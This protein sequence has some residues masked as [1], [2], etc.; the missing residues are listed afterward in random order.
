[1]NRKHVVLRVLS[2]LILIS[3]LPGCSVGVHGCAYL[4]INEKAVQEKIDQANEDVKKE[5]EQGLHDE[6]DTDMALAEGEILKVRL[7]YG[8]D[9]AGSEAWYRV[10]IDNDRNG[11]YDYV[12]ITAYTGFGTTLKGY[13]EYTFTAANFN[14][15]WEQEEYYDPLTIDGSYRMTITGSNGHYVEKNLTWNSSLNDGR[16]GWEEGA[17][18]LVYDVP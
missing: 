15:Q 12:E 5:V 18:M 2:Y 17:G 1:M 3:F 7:Y 9:T 13:D 6:I 10:R 4:G 8:M 11:W 14:H 16:G